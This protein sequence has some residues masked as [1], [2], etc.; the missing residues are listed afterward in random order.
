MPLK[1]AGNAARNDVIEKPDDKTAA[2]QERLAAVAA[3]EPPEPLALEPSDA[4]P[5]LLG[6]IGGWRCY[7]L[8]DRAD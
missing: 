4:G 5:R 6:S 3:T 7:V 2:M 8:A 1:Q